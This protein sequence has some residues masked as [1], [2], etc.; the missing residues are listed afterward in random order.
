MG[1]NQLRILEMGGGH[2]PFPFDEEKYAVVRVDWNPVG[3]DVVHDL[4]EFPYPFDDNS[5]D[6]IYSS[7]CIEHLENKLKVFWEIHRLL[8]NECIGIIRVPHI[9]WSDAWNF[10]HFHVWKLGSM[11]CFVNSQWY[12][13]STFPNFELLSERLHWRNPGPIRLFENSAEKFCKP[14]VIRKGRSKYKFYHRIVNYIINQHKY[15]SE[16]F[17][18]YWLFGI[19]EIEYIIKAKKV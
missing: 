3:T 19:K 16:T 9:T 12:G 18:Y 17:L 8:K 13:V 14:E 15:F 1:Y 7:H 6:I 11:N 10:D 2:N 5:F 4:N